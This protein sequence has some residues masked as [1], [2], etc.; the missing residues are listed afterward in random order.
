MLR[1]S[2]LG[3]GALPWFFYHPGTDLSNTMSQK[4]PLDFHTNRSSRGFYKMIRNVYFHE[5]GSLRKN[6]GMCEEGGG[7]G[8][9]VTSRVGEM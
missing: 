2:H 7:A 4:E 9:S 6:Q 3:I 8:G 5:V 1:L